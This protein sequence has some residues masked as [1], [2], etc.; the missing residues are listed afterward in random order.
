MKKKKKRLRITKTILDNK[1]TSEGIT[2][3]DFQLYYRAMKIE[4][5]WYW[6]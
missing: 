1:R 2:I 5:T 6:H 4:G 3:P